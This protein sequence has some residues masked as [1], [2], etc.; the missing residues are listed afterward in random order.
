MSIQKIARLAG[1]SVATVSRVL[2]NSDTVKEKNR[3][4]VLQAIK[5][6][7]Y[8]PNLLARQLRTARSYMILVMVSNIANPFCAEV[9]KGIEEEA[10]KHGYRI[11]LCNSGSDL[12]RSTSG[13]QLLSGKMVDGIITMNALSSLPELTTM[14]G[15]APWVQCAEYADNGS[16]SCVGIND[17]DAAQGA[18]SRL[19]DSGRK[20]IAL[21]NHDL[22]YRYSRL[23]ERGYKSV[24]HVRELD[25]QQVTYASDLSAAA[26]KKAMEQLLAL[27]EKPDAVFAVSDSL[28]AGALRAIAQAGLRVPEDIAVIGFDGTELAEVV[29]PQL[30]TVEQPS[31]AIG[32]T[33]VTLLMK[34]IDNPDAAVERVM[35]D[36][37]V[38][39]RASA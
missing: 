34:R 10:E 29:S 35:M 32:R 36:W 20:R 13:L 33:A 12:A 1:V 8:Q 14:I 5:E 15:D 7:N 22:S 2:N 38:I 3:E 30:T 6:S 26:G 39:P 16:I 37:R 27:D 11:L 4:R 19:V 18:V 21:I 9:V 17:V 31:R 25:Y 28:A 23:R 24:L